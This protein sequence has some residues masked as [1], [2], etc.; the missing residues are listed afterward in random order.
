MALTHP[1]ERA[2]RAPLYLHGPEGSE[3]LEGPWEEAGERLE[4]AGRAV[5][6]TT[7][8][9]WLTAVLLDPG[10][11][12][13][14]GEDWP[15]YRGMPA[16][17]GRLRFAV[18][19]YVMK[20]AAATALDVPVHSVQ[21][22]RGPGGRPVVRGPGTGVQIALA[23]TG[24]LIVVGVSRTGRIGLHA[25]P[26]D[27]DL[28]APLLRGPAGPQQPGA[29]AGPDTLT[30]S[31]R[32]ARLLRELT[33]RAARTA[34]TY[35]AADPD[36]AKHDAADRDG[37]THDAAD[38]DGADRDGAD[39]E[40]AARCG[41]ARFT[42]AGTQPAG[43]PPEAVGEWTLAAHLVQDRYLVGEAHGPRP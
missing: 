28:R 30:G 4:D 23:H 33:L 37:A 18:S 17:A 2:P 24:E 3:G 34:A 35:D 12:P 14:L 36:A 39:R 19:R 9:Q 25:E 41:A 21:L 8:G 11:R 32:R 5:V 1:A 6:C 40:A 13:L 20:Y 31:E 42:A 22:G 10:L 29:G 38:R 16:A 26:A 7:W 27:P 15:A 43:G